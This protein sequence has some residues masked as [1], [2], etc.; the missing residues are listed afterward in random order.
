MG[1]SFHYAVPVF[2]S[3]HHSS[4]GLL[5]AFANEIDNVNKTS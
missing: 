3:P 2:V 4:E 1:L 5:F